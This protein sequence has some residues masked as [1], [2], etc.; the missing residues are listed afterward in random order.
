MPR[1]NNII[2]LKNNR[3][4]LRSHLTPAEARLWAYLKNN[5]LGEKFR[6]QHSVGFY[7][8][9]F[10]CPKRKLAIE[11]DGSP[12]NTEQGYQ[13]DQNRTKDLNSKGITVLRFENKDIFK[14]SDGVLAE[15]KKYLR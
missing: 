13:N 5:Q 1:L 10:Y 7:I 4:N 6:R 11:L 12:H 9:D 15:I 14:N 2:S 3:K 8:L